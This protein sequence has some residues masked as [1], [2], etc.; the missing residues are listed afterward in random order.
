VNKPAIIFVLLQTGKSANGGIESV[1]QVICR[2]QAFRPVVLTNL[3]SAQTERL[4]AEGIELHVVQEQVSSG[5]RNHPLGYA[6]SYWRYHRVLARLLGKTR[7]RVVHANDP[8]AF[9][10]SLSA[11]KTRRGVRIALNM[12]DTLDPGRPPPRRRYAGY[13][14]LAD[15]LIFLSQEMAAWFEAMAG[16]TPRAVDVT[17]S[18]VDLQRFSPRP[19][20]RALEPP[21]V[22][23]P[24]VVSRKKGQLDF[25]RHVAP[26]VVASGARIWFAGDFDPGR[27]SYSAACAKAAGPLGEAVRF[28]GFRSDMPELI[29]QARVIAIPSRH[30]GLMR[31][32]IETMAIG[33]PVVSTDVCSAR[34]ML[35]RVSGRAGIVVPLGR[36]REMT[37]A[38]VHYCT[39][40][41]AA[42]QDGQRGSETA[43]RLF[44]PAAVVARFEAAYLAMSQ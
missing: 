40:R 9:Q 6:T 25:L 39:D 5:L 31:G 7:A 33:R 14:R 43:R 44:D 4:V 38:I 15:R 28:L 22:L 27:D 29:A 1:C 23:V 34:E 30:E 16:R 19:L 26:A 18:I 42:E 10:L 2:L 11:V 12:R 3:H 24:G 41:A 17:Y 35:E 20:S 36:H 37:D 21:V 8:L 32:M 13:F